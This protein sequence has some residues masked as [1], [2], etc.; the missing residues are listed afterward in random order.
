MPCYSPLQA[1]R[2]KKLP[3]GKR[4]I[5]WKRA[6]RADSLVDSELKLP[7]GQCIG[8]RLE[9]SRQWAIRCVHESQLHERNCFVTLTYDQTHLPPGGSVS[10]REFQ[11]FMKR[12]RKVAGPGVR[13]FHCGEYG[14]ELARP[15]YH[16]CLFNFDFDDKTLWSVRNG[17][18]LYR[19]KLLESLWPFGFS[20]V[21]DVT[22]ESAA[23]V[24]RYV[25]KKVTGEPKEAHYKGLNPEY[26]SMSRGSKKIGT[27]GIGKGWY[28]KFKLDVYPGDF[29]VLRSMKL[30]PPKFY[31]SLYDL[32]SHDEYLKLKAIRAARSR[33][34]V[35]SRLPDGRV[36]K[37]DDNDSIRLPV[38]EA[39]KKSRVKLL[40][41]SMEASYEA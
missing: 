21:G 2:G 12:L 13:Y 7:C 30:R 24:A 19:S 6:Q 10:V 27:G 37:V 39:V 25:M 41:R 15:H 22:F 17:V 11:L 9:R 34:L 40:T 1:W 29:V 26:V 23:Y 14:E 28:D 36:V 20:T 33:R 18:R 5:V 32:D 38:K 35:D 4:E 31:D 8:C 16:A 3:S